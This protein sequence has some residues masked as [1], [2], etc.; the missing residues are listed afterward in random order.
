MR[1]SIIGDFRFISVALG[2]LYARL[3]FTHFRVRTQKYRT[4]SFMNIIGPAKISHD[5]R[6]GLA[7]VNW[8]LTRRA[9]CDKTT[10]IFSYLE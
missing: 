7:K 5:K 8:I 1:N 4:E 10:G 2:I 3:T 9:Y 6:L